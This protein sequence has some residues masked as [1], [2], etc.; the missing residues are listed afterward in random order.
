MGIVGYKK[1]ATVKK[2]VE[3]LN[4]K[5]KTVKAGKTYRYKVRTYIKVGKKEILQCIYGLR[6]DICNKPKR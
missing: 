1:I 2:S 5:D 4:Y 3:S 6:T